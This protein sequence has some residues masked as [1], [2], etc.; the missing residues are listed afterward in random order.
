MPQGNVDPIFSKW[1][2]NIMKSGVNKI[3]QMRMEYH[4][5]P[6]RKTKANT[7]IKH[8]KKASFSARFGLEN[9]LWRSRNVFLFFN[10]FDNF[11]ID[12]FKLSIRGNSRNHFII[13][14]E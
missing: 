14:K 13:K 6:L 8:H 2:E 5:N 11:F 4:E 10:G 12:E 9:R 7:K 1:V 3:P